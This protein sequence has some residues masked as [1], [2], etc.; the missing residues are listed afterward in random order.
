MAFLVKEGGGMQNEGLTP[1]GVLQW[2]GV[3]Q[4]SFVFESKS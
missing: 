1:S 3:R 2:P 4:L